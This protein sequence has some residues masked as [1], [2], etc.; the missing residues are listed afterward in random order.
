MGRASVPDRLEPGFKAL[1]ESAFLDQLKR[2]Y[3]QSLEESYLNPSEA[4]IPLQGLQ[5]VDLIF[6]SSDLA[7]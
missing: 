6:S 2:I 3:L 5:S 4:A 1:G 7:R